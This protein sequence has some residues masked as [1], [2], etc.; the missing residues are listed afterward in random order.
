MSVKV[1]DY[2]DVNHPPKRVFIRETKD[3]SD[4]SNVAKREFVICNDKNYNDV[5][6]VKKREINKKECVEVEGSKPKRFN[7]NKEAPSA[8]V[9]VDGE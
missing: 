1:K 6:V 4:V 5:T 7:Y 3:Y 8:M 9:M 2:S